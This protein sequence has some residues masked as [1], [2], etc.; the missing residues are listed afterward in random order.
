ML[1]VRESGQEAVQLARAW[2]IWTLPP[3]E[4]QALGSDDG[5]SNEDDAEGEGFEEE[6]EDQEEEESE[7]SGTPYIASD[8]G[9]D[10][11]FEGTLPVPPRPSSPPRT[12]PT[13]PAPPQPPV[14]FPAQERVCDSL[15][16]ALCHDLSCNGHPATSFCNFAKQGVS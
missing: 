1:D 8:A 11:E 13:L 10:V 16:Q 2:A 3:I 9:S 14:A 7:S 15:P 4:L 6:D 12:Q 5:D